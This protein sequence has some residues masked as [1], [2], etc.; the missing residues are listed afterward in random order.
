M[1]FEEK[2]I[3]LKDG[4]MAI[5]RN[6][7]VQDAKKMINYMKTSLEETEFLARYPEE[8]S[9]NVEQEEVWI[10]R[11]CC[12]SNLLAIACYVDNE[13][14]GFCEL[15]FFSNIKKSHRAFGRCCRLLG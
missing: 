14:A 13:I 7:C 5:F 11:R 6:P 3:M 10:A 9:M 4:R 8:F 12:D 2:K 1:I 15:R